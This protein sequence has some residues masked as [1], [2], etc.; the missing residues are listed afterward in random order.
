MTT[1]AS[2]LA[3][4]KVTS[5]IQSGDSTSLLQIALFIGVA[6]LAV[7]LLIFLYKKFV[8]KKAENEYFEGMM[9][10]PPAPTSTNTTTDDDEYA[11]TQTTQTA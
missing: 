5:S 7:L 6:V 1:I 4:A 10:E 11:G 2:K 3:S 8:A 9:E